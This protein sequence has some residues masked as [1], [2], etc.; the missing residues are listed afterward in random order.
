[1]S[2]AFDDLDALTLEVIGDPITFL[3][4]A[5]SPGTSIMAWVD[6]SP[7]VVDFGS[8]S[9]VSAQASMQVRKIDVALPT[10]D[11][12]FVLPRTGQTYRPTAW[13]HSRC[14]RLWNIDLVKVTP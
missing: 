7:P 6:H 1:M 13:T 2:D 12:R 3:A 9:A 5:Q 10:R 4:A 8:S 14:G 11:D